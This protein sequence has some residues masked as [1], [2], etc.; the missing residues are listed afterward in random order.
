M[1]LKSSVSLINSLML[2]L[3]E[4]AVVGRGQPCML[5]RDFNVE[6]T[7]I[8]C[9]LKGITFG[10]W[11]DLQGAWANAS[12]IDAGVTCK[13]DW[14]RPGGTRRDFILGCPLAAAALESC[15]VD[16]SRWI[17]PHFRS[18]LPFRGPAGLLRSLS[19]AGLLL[20]GQLLGFL[21]W[22]SLGVL[23]LLR[24]GI[25]GRFMIISCSLSLLTKLVLLMLP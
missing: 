25:F 24:F 5:A 17:Q 21:R 22:T 6:P 14:A 15:W 8:P 10:L 3:G 19:L 2:P 12:G 9:L 20:F 7:K 23:G 13:K 1:T 11:F 18:G 4:L 16:F